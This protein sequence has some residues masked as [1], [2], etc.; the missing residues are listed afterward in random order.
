MLNS[1]LMKRGRKKGTRS[2]VSNVK[3]EEEKILLRNDLFTAEIKDLWG[4]E[5]K[6]DPEIKDFVVYRDEITCK[7]T[8]KVPFHRFQKPSL[9]PPVEIPHPGASYNPAYEDHQ[10]LLSKAL[11][12]E[13][14]KQQQELHLKRVL[15][16][17]FPTKAEAPTPESILK[18]MS[19]GLFDDEEMEEEEED[20][21]QPI[22]R[23]R[24]PPVTPDD[25]L[26]KSR[27][28]KRKEMKEQLRLKKVEQVHKKQLNQVYRIRSIKS[29]IKKEAEVS[30]QRQEKKDS[31]KN[32]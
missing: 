14:V 25:R 5:E 20:A 8:P 32:R 12:V 16:D 28:R 30:Q 13:E 31:K 3:E 1:E 7:R 17:M 10:E 9:L 23:F 6:I 18:E 27:K 15:T 2:Q 21:E 4:E 26:P 24:N 19:Q 11:K 29:E 22:S